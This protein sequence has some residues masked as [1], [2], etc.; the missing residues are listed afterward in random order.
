M[1]T[2][3]SLS[4]KKTPPICTLMSNG[5]FSTGAADGS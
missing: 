4:S 5:G 2:I 1:K 3:R